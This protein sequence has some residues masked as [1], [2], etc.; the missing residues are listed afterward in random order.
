M[1]RLFLAVMLALGV[2]TGSAAADEWK[3]LIGPDDLAA[4]IAAGG[5]TVLDIRAPEDYAAGH[6]PG[7]LSAPYGSWRGPPENPGEPLTD[8]QLTD[9]LQSLGITPESRVVITYAGTDQT[10]FGAAAR[11]YWTLKSAGLEKIAIL[12]GGVGTWVAAGKALSTVPVVAE[13]S[14]AT[15]TLSEKWRVTREEVAQVVKGERQAVL[16]DARPPEFWRG[17]TKHP[18]AARPG[19]IPGAPN[20][21]H[22]VWFEGSALRLSTAERVAELARE[23]APVEGARE[24]VSFCNTGHWAATNWFAL[25]EL[26]GL[27]N[28]KLYPESVV[29]WTIAG[30]EVVPGR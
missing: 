1:I 26:A 7:A 4:L 19:T 2:G 17:E 14:D 27:A 22:A 28:V 20:L 25:S 6:V 16:I 24:V 3:K 30:G 11:V 23:K 29:G 15:F 12:N 8:A 10:D 18:A 21:P 5:V 13:L 9:R